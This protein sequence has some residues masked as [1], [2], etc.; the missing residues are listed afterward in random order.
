MTKKLDVFQQVRWQT[1]VDI[2]A[3]YLGPPLQPSFAH[4]PPILKRSRTIW[5][6]HW[7]RIMEIWKIIMYNHFSGYDQD[8]SSRRPCICST[9]SKNHLSY[10]KKVRW[11]SKSWMANIRGCLRFICRVAP[12]QPS[13]CSLSTNPQMILNRSE[14]KARW[15]RM[16]VLHTLWVGSVSL[17]NGSLWMAHR[18]A[19][20]S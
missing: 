17:S 3:L 4:C 15:D 18:C 19:V 14:I 2:C 20:G 5:K 12:L 10:D 9:M 13:P 6:V 8:L 1:Y 16:M 7:D 11:F